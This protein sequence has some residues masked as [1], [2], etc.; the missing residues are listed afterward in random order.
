M[1]LRWSSDVQPCL[2]GQPANAGAGMVRCT[3]PYLVK[4]LFRRSNS[5]LLG[6]SEAALPLRQGSPSILEYC[7]LQKT[8]GVSYIYLY[9]QSVYNIVPH[10]LREIYHTKYF[11]TWYIDIC[12]LVMYSKTEL[13][14]HFSVYT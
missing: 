9:N 14:D 13:S 11:K 4:K 2:K 5:G 7:K 1:P 6:F 3:Q 12:L 10:S 8:V